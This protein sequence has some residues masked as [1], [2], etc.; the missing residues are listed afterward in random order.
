LY[1]AGGLPAD[2]PPDTALKD[3]EALVPGFETSLLRESLAGEPAEETSGEPL[4][5]AAAPEPSATPLPPNPAPGGDIPAAATASHPGSGDGD[6]TGAG[7]TPL[8]A[9][10]VLPADQV[11][12]RMTLR[13]VSQQCSVPLDALL[14][15]LNLSTD[16]NPDTQLKDLIS[17]GL[18]LEVT[19]VQ[20]AVAA[21]QAP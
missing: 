8:P 20:A 6:G 4:E 15:A 21:L 9:G 16:I 17:Q 3:L 19:A 13:A 1:A 12:G 14:K 18:I 2:I 7:P 11:K 5:T 10:Q